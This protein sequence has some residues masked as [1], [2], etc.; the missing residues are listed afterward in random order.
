MNKDWQD[1]FERVDRL[2]E[3]S[4]YEPLNQEERQFLFDTIDVLRYESEHG[5]TLQ[6]EG[7]WYYQQGKEESRRE[8]CSNISSTR[9][10]S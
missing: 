5:L 8:P 10:A 9:K 3:K 7:E 2:R 4:K 6:D 1:D